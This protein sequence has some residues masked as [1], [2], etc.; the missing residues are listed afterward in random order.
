MSEICRLEN[1]EKYY[2][3]QKRGF[4]DALVGVPKIFVKALDGVT[5]SI[6]RDKVVAI[7]GESG[8]GKTTMGKVFTTL[9][10]PTKG[11]A[12]FEGKKIQKQTYS[13]CVYG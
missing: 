7:V 10:V 3:A 9:E 11:E 12:Y 6:P 2:L 4:I 1:V 8:S 5:I 13:N